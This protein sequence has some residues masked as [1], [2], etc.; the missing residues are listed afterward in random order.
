VS[1]VFS[2]SD[3]AFAGFRLMRERPRA[4]AIW[5]ALQAAF[6][7]T[8][9]ALNGV[10]FASNA[11]Q[12]REVIAINQ[13]DPARALVE[14]GRML[15]V[16]LPLLIVD[17]ALFLFVSAVQNGAIYRAYLEPQRSRLGYL[18]LSRAELGLALAL[19]AY[20]V[21]G[22]LYLFAVLFAFD[23]ALILTAGLTG[24]VSILLH[25]ALAGVLIGAI[26]YPSVRLSLGLPMTF[27]EQRVRILQSWKLTQGRFWPLF[28]AYLLTLVYVVLAGLVAVIMFAVVA[29]I[30]SRAYGGTGADAW[31][32]G[33]AP[34]AAQALTLLI[35]LPFQALLLAATFTIWRGPSAEAYRALSDARPEPG[36]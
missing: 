4:L 8:S 34:V 17:A 24:P 5:T 25:L 10:V 26:A 28:G 12:F 20:F 7:A 13:V 32:A 6:I 15:P 3:A 30:I 1:A 16:L 14:M 18:R 36:A 11:A 22:L 35:N 19:V 2:A 27:A 9:Y 33:E 31:R 21:L 23:L 29:W